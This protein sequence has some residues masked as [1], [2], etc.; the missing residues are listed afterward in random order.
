MGAARYRALFL[1][2]RVFIRVFYPRVFIRV[3]ARRG[4]QRGGR[5][6]ST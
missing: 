5:M 1:S 2:A 4:V 3:I 6:P